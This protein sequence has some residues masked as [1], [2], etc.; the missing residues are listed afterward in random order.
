MRSPFVEPTLAVLL[1][2][3]AVPVAGQKATSEIGG[4]VVDQ[5][6][7]VLSG[8][9]KAPE[10]SAKAKTGHDRTSENRFWCQCRVVK[11]AATIIHCLAMKASTVSL[12]ACGFSYSSP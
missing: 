8:V 9:A 11:L 3:L 12:K 4:R 10:L 7:G 5:N 1:L 6:G 2:T